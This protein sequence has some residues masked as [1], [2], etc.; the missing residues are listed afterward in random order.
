MTVN[1][2]TNFLSLSNVLETN[3]LLETRLENDSSGNV[4]YIGYATTPGALTSASVWYIR[5]LSY[6]GNGFVDYIQLPSNGYGFLYSWDNR[7]TYF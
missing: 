2:Y 1:S 6:D 5:K 4:L 3:S 7:A